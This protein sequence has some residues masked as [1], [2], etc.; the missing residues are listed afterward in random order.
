MSSSIPSVSVLALA[1]L[2]TSPLLLLNAFPM[3]SFLGVVT[4]LMAGL[5][6]V[7]VLISVYDVPVVS[8]SVIPVEVH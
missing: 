6:A 4:N 3:S 8:S 5:A 2:S 1:P 7:D